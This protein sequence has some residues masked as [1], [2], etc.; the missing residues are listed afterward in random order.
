M[1]LNRPYFL[2]FLAPL[3]WGGHVVVAKV[4][5]AEVAPMTLTLLRWTVALTV[6]TPFA[7]RS[8]K[9]EWEVI[10]QHLLLLFIC[11]I[12][13]FAGFNMLYYLALEYT[14]ALN[15]ALIQAAIPMLIL[16]INAI[17]FRYRMVLPQVVGLILAFIG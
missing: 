11:G 7:W 5:T 12:M 6:I 8:V 16:L 1:L 4:A 15:V 13:G 3:I 14:T 17:V 10:R 2:L 9:R